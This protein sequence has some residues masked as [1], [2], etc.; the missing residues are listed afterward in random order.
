MVMEI[1]ELGRI[2]LESFSGTK[3][4]IREVHRYKN[5]ELVASAFFENLRRIRDLN[6]KKAEEFETIYEYYQNYEAAI[7]Y[8]RSRNN[9]EYVISIKNLF[10]GYEGF[11]TYPIGSRD[12]L[13]KK[14]KEE[15]DLQQ[16]FIVKAGE[17]EISYTFKGERLTEVIFDIKGYEDSYHINTVYSEDGKTC[18]VWKKY[19]NADYPTIIKTYEFAD[20]MIIEREDD[21][22]KYTVSDERNRVIRIGDF[23][24]DEEKLHLFEHY[25][26]TEDQE[27]FSKIMKDIRLEIFDYDEFDNLV[28]HQVSSYRPDFSKNRLTPHLEEIEYFDPY[29]IHYGS[30][31]CKTKDDYDDY[32]GGSN[33]LEYLEGRVNEYN[34]KDELIAIYYIENEKKS[35]A[36]FFSSTY[37]STEKYDEYGNTIEYCRE[38][39]VTNTIETIR[40]EIIY[41]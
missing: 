16:F 11:S 3:K 17:D 7:T 12:F 38:N 18:K 25:M 21:W 29:N 14:L 24:Y 20:N 39:K 1:M 15:G 27:T 40:H 19:I 36:E 13:K 32:K 30:E 22:I 34:K 37:F 28:L 4:N 33:R 31:Y 6:F 8:D 41:Q 35:H 26:Q 2:M 23:L 9:T 10:D 5:G